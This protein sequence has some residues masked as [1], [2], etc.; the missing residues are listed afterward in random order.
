MKR[1]LLPWL[2]VLTACAGGAGGVDPIDFTLQLQPYTPLNQADLFD[3][4]ATIKVAVDRGTGSLEVYDLGA[5]GGDGTA[6][7]PALAALADADINVYG[8]DSG[9]AMVAFGRST[10]WTLPD[11]DDPK[12][13]ILMARVGAVGAMTDLPGDTKLVGGVAVADGAGR[14]VLFGGGEKGLDRSNDGSPGV[15]RFDAGRPNTNLSFVR[16]DDLPPATS[17]NDEPVDGIVAHT[18]LVLTGSHDR[19]GWVLL[20][21]GAGGFSGAS[22]VTDRML[23]WNPDDQSVVNLGADG[24]LDDGVF[25]HTAD[26]F[27]AGYVALLGGAVGRASGEPITDGVIAP[28]Q[29]ASLF[30]PRSRT[31]TEIL[32][33][34]SNGPLI[35]HDAATLDGEAVLVC[36]GLNIEGSSGQYSASDRCDI[37]DQEA[38]LR[39]TE[40]L[41]IPLM[42]HDLISL[43]DGRVLLTGGFTTTGVVGEGGSVEPNGSV[44]YYS[45]GEGWARLTAPLAVPR[46]HHATAV[47]PDGRV[48]IVGGTTNTSNALWSGDGATGCVEIYDPVFGRT[49]V[50]GSCDSD[51]LRGALARPVV[52][53]S[54]AA[55]PDMGVLIV[56][57][58]DE[59]DDSVGQV[60]WFVGGIPE[61]E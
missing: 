15:L 30:E 35:F 45:S 52:L 41:P 18:A 51:G 60:A 8:Y 59:D 38:I 34:N 58:A 1:S 6:T 3:D 56:G 37:V 53:P 7:S 20:S 43:P 25:H 12:V 32:T 29:S 13:P 9:G 55:D 27:G 23:M 21:G 47:L 14:F 4:V 16:L 24:R 57:G 28:R 31:V 33:D 42:H 50:V 36:G 61:P 22:S 40:P 2:G 44:Y 39:S 26:E 46:A 5:P 54:V 19:Q 10:G 49:E 17:V 48:L 11:E